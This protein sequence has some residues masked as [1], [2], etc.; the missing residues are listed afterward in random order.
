MRI[1][2]EMFGGQTASR[3]RGIGRYVRNLAASLSALA[4]HRGHD[5][6]LYAQDGPSVDGIPTSAD[7]PLRLL[8]PEPA[9]REAVGRLVRENPDRLDALVLTNPLELTPGYDIPG[10]P[11]EQSLALTAVVHD[12]IPWVFPDEYLR[13]SP[14]PLFARRFFWALEGPTPEKLL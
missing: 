11:A 7:V 4:R 8:R 9:L 10:R 14:D 12:L 1:G 5:L 6:V 13:C 2:L 3:H